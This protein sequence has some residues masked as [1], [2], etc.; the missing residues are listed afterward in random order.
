VELPLPCLV[1]AEPPE[2][3]IARLLRRELFADLLRRYPEL[4][5]DGSGILHPDDPRADRSAFVVAY[6]HTHPAG[7]GALRPLEGEIEIAE[8]KRIYVRPEV[9]R[10]GVARA[11]LARLEQLAVES[12]YR[13]LRLETGN[14]QPEAVALYEAY[15][16]V[17]IPPFGRFIG[18][19]VSICFEKPLP[20]PSR[21]PASSGSR[22]AFPAA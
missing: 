3:E 7:C 21:A 15:G 13:T 12:G 2:S 20:P 4:G 11:I 8:L 6:C 17:R 10:Q 5:T 9:R 22:P 16:F 19:P 14:R 18:N 1:R